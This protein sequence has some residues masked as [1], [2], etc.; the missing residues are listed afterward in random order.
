MT[1]FASRIGIGLL[2]AIFC[3]TAAAQAENR[4]VFAHLFTVPT[5][6]LP[7]GADAAGKILELEKW[8]VQ[9]CGGYTRLG[10]G[11]GAW[12]NDQGQVELQGN[13]VY[14]VT[15]S[16]DFAK[17][18]AARLSKDFGE[19]MPYILVFPADQFLK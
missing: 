3:L 15:A 9:S 11:N 4:Q 2:L 13:A 1:R 14:L 16:R 17:D 7:G 5:D 18:L 19:R 10:A 12:K 8:L 6:D